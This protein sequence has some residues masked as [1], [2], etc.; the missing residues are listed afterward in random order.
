MNK[1]LFL[2]SVAGIAGDMFA[3]AF[4]DAGLVSLSDLELLPAQLGFSKVRIEARLVTKATMRATHLRVVC[5]AGDPA[6]LSHSHEITGSVAAHAHAASDTHLIVDAPANHRHT[7]YVDIDRRILESQ[8]EMPVRELARKIFR[9]LAE[10]EAAAHGSDLAHVAFHE[11]GSI[12]SIVDVVMAAYCFNR[13]GPVRCL[14]SPIR[15]GRGLVEIAHGMQPIPP[16]A[17]A[18]LLS[19][20]QIAGT[21]AGI[22]RENVELSTPTGIAILKAIASEFVDHLPAGIVRS[23]G[24]GAG[25][26]DLGSY[27]N[28]FR[29]FLLEATPAMTNSLPYESDRIV[30]IT[31]NIDDDTG[32]HLAWLG[33]SLLAQGALD[34]S[35]IPATGKKS[36]PVI[37]LSLLVRE[38]QWTRF[39]DWLLKNSTTF[40]LRHRVWNRL[41]LVRRF[42]RRTTA[43]G[44]LTYKTGLSTDGKLLKEKIEFEDQRKCWDAHDPA[45]D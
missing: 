20:M 4:V 17:S 3:A 27:P 41:K 7:H 14:A 13:I 26:M 25:T 1:I 24:M 44:T 29:V 8:L 37:L 33:E 39:A 32:E 31:C 40:G 22:R 12:D 43:A 11:L 18:R 21:P 38:D 2:E 19:G 42:E 34:I 28:V 30:E 15:P 5:E 23:Q 9:L 6:P 16:P 45:A 35:L 10:A 36:R